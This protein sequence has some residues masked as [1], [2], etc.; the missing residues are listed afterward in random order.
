MQQE[1]E[2]GRARGQWSERPVIEA[3]IDATV[4]FTSVPLFLPLLTTFLRC[5]A[6]WMDEKN[7]EE[8]RDG[9]RE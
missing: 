6:V 7:R 2:G 9:R 5:P 8:K 4:K 1:K 3:K